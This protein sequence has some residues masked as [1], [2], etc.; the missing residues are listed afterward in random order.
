MLSLNK[1]LIRKIIITDD[2]S[3]SLYVPSLNENYHSSYGARQEAEHIFI[4]SALAFA[5]KNKKTLNI[6]EIGFGTGLNA[7]LTLQYAKEKCLDLNYY[8]I[9]KY[10]I[11]EEEYQQLNF[12]SNR[13]GE[14]DAFLKL[15]QSDWGLTLEIEAGFK[16][17]KIQADF[18]EMNLPSDYFDVV[19][20]DA[21]GPE[22][23][24]DLWSDAVFKDVYKSMKNGAVLTT[25][26][27]K[28]EVRRT[29]K[30]A[31]FEV[32]KIQGPIGKREISR[33]IKPL[34]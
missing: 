12:A 7:F 30:A 32:R 29:M 25:Y 17:R 31:G 34:D 23:Q 1:K 18:K 22:V 13:A 4:K 3:H 15:H 24:A 26:S 20:F 16:L 9:E 14:Q 11:T 5:S 33:A 28:G 2:G 27:V 19:Y 8:A 6:L 21:F 10:P